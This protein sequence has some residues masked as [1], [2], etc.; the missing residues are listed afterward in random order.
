MHFRQTFI[1][2]CHFMRGHQTDKN[3][4]ILQISPELWRQASHCRGTLWKAIQFLPAYGASSLAHVV[5][6]PDTDHRT[7]EKINKGSAFAASMMAP[8][9]LDYMG[10]CACL[11]FKDCI[12]AIVL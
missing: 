3:F 5:E 10:R 12:S 2:S 4:V 6:N 9:I 8:G 7:T 11:Q 1:L